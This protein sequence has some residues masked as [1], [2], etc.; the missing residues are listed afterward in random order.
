MTNSKRRHDRAEYV[1]VDVLTLGLKHQHIRILP[2]HV[3]LQH[4]TN[5][6]IAK[7][8]NMLHI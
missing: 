2:H 1:D 6:C 5:Y 8:L 4:A 3:V 7:Y